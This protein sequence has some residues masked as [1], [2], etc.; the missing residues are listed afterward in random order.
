MSQGPEPDPRLAK[1]SAVVVRVEGATRR[2]ARLVTAAAV[3]GGAS[4]LALW[5]ATDG[6]RIH[7]LGKF[8][9]A[10]LVLP[11]LYLVPAAWL[12]NVRFSLLALLELPGKLGGVTMRRGPELV[13]RA[14]REIPAEHGADGGPRLPPGRLAAARALRGLVRDYGEVVGSWATVAQLVTPTF[15][16]L[17]ALA[18]LAVP[19]LV[20]VAAVAGLLAA[21]S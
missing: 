5:W 11:V 16:A 18:L 17:T 10:S 12:L 9:A 21:F 4:G 1:L 14:R 8:T 20:A 7:D 6:R 3:V 19:I 2:L 15:W 13:G